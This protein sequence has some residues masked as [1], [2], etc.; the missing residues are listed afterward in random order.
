MDRRLFNAM[1][2]SA[3]AAGRLLMRYYGRLQPS[4]IAYKNPID[5]VTEADKT[6][7]SLVRKRLGRIFP[8]ASFLG[9]EEGLSGR[10]D[11]DLMFVL[12]PLDGTTNF[13][14]THPFFCVS[15]ACREHG[16]VTGGVVYAP[17]LRTIY[18]AVAGN[19]AFRDGRPVRVSRTPDLHHSLLITGFA[20]VR[21]GRKPDG[22]PLF[23]N[24]IYNCQGI[25]RSGSAALDLC[26]VADGRADLFWEIGLNPWDISAGAL[27]VAEAG[28]RVTNLGGDPEFTVARSIVASNGLIHDEFLTVAKTVN[29]R[30]AG[31]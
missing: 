24:L 21:E 8:S 22:V 4:D 29:P 19:G 27:L 30:Y 14:H 11:A 28:G 9:E 15:L 12:D 20:C 1:H 23:T 7:E 2:S 25:R 17:A 13:V 5:L 6:A 10:T 18:H 26:F 31:K 16:R 3:L